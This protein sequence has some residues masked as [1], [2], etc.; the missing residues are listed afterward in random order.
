MAEQQLPILENKLIYISGA[1]VHF[2]SEEEC[3]LLLQTNGVVLGRY[4]FSPKHAKRLNQL[5]G[6]QLAEYESKYGVLNTELAPPSTQSDSFGFVA[7]P[8]QESEAAH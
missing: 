2:T 5:L 4:V 8:S 3:M 6:K 7:K 1:N